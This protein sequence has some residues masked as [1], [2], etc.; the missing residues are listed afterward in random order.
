M[1]KRSEKKLI[2]IEHTV[3]ST[4]YIMIYDNDT[5]QR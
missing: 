5:L 2:I 3:A 4:P 1:E